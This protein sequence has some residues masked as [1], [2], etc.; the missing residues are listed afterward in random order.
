MAL[1]EESVVLLDASDEGS[2]PSTSV[3]RATSR[4]IAASR[5]KLT[6]LRALFAPQL[7]EMT[8]Y[9]SK[10]PTKRASQ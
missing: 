10:L 1:S 5:A 2:Q 4:T 6:V 8:A 3:S 7:E 9:A